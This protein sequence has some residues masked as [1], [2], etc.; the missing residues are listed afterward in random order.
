MSGGSRS[1]LYVY[2]RVAQADVP[3][4]LQTVRDFQRRQSVVTMT[5]RSLRHVASG[6]V[7]VARAEGFTGHAQS[8]L[9]RFA[10]ELPRAAR[11]AR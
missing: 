1:E 8:V 2:Y 5:E 10:A 6:V 4:A 11:R 3:A 9:T 7:A